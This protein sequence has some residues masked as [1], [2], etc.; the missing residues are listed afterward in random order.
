MKDFQCC[1]TCVHFRIYREKK[2]LVSRCSRLEFDTKT[3]YKFDCW[4]P[5]E[6]VLALIAKEK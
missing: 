1:A 4:T 6:R 2:A 3:H 5:K